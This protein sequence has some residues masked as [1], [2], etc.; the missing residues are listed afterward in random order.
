VAEAAFP[1][2][3]DPAAG[4]DGGTLD[5]A[6]SHHCFHV[7]RLRPGDALAVVDGRGLRHEGLLRECG[8]EKCTYEVRRTVAAGTRPY[9]LHVA[10]AP[11]KNAERFEWFLEKAVETGIDEVTPL[12]CERSVRNRVSAARLHKIMVGAMK[13]S[14]QAAL[15][16]LHP[17]TA[18]GQLVERNGAAA[19]FICSM[20]GAAPRPAEL[21]NCRD[22]L[23]LVGPEG[24]F[25]AGERGLA[26]RHGFMAL[27]L[28]RS[29]LRTETA[30]VY[31]CSMVSF[32]HALAE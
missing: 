28:G 5:A 12:A 4:P 19:K 9:R 11:P 13:Q 20:D 29:R 22:S 30:G 25:T 32:V 6:E 8:P 18:F 27:S 1:V 7:L 16:R 10:L 15:P 3:Y 21:K 17:V 2:F 26:E 14:Q 24:D 23:F 31:V